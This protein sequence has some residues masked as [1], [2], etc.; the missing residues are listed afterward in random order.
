M[1]YGTIP[2]NAANAAQYYIVEVDENN[3][4]RILPYNILANDFFKT[5]SNTDGDEYLVYYIDIPSGEMNYRPGD[6]YENSDT[7]YFDEDATA[8]I[9][10]ITQNTCL[11]T[12]PQ[13]KDNDCIY[14]YEIVFQS[15]K[16]NQNIK[17]FRILL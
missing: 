17:S 8:E 6:R 7:P 5:P 3:L 16:G 1:T 11:I 4:V 13:A 2:P 10:E 9:T 15:D 14:S 12:F